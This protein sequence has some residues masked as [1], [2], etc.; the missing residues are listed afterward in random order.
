MITEP[1]QSKYE[2]AVQSKI[3]SDVGD[4]GLA[5]ATQK[6]VSSRK[7]VYDVESVLAS[8]HEHAQ[9]PKLDN[10]SEW[11]APIS[12]LRKVRV[13]S[14][15]SKTERRENDAVN[16]LYIINNCGII[17]ISVAQDKRTAHA[18][19]LRALLRASVPHVD[20][21]ASIMDVSMTHVILGRGSGLLAIRS[22]TQ[23]LRPLRSEQPPSVEHA[24]VNCSE[25]VWG[26]TRMP[27]I[28]LRHEL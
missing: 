3:C 27:R 11:P 21:C 2:N 4:G 10:T 18:S 26:C 19:S 24:M 15:L 12:T 28:V 22:A 7:W 9:G 8:T 13:C 14:S 20:S 25:D 6:V 16:L 23:A 5:Q 1:K 17:R